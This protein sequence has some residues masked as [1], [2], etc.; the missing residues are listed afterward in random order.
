M[1]AD[2]EDLEKFDA[3]EIFYPLKN[4]RERGIDNTKRIW[5]HIPSGRWNENPL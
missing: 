5:I 1:I 3:S 4:Q 2:L